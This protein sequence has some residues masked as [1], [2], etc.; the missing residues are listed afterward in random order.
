MLHR[1]ML[2]KEPNPR[3]SEDLCRKLSNYDKYGVG[4]LQNGKLVSLN[5]AF[6]LIFGYSMDSLRGTNFTDLIKRDFRGDYLEML[7]SLEKGNSA[8]TYRTPCMRADGYEIWTEESHS[9]I[10]WEGSSAVLMTVRE[11]DPSGL[12]ETRQQENVPDQKHNKRGFGLGRI[13]GKS[14]AMETVYELVLKATGSDSNVFIS[15]ESGT[16]KELVAR[17]IHEMSDRSKG[18]FVPINSG[19]IPDTLFESEFFGY[20]KGAF[21]G[22]YTD[23]HGFFDLAQGGTLFLDE[24]GEL[25][26]NAQVKLLRAIETGEYTPVGQNREKS[27]E[28]RI[29]AATNRKLIEE[30]EN[31]RIREDFFYRIYVIPIMLPPLRD[32]K[33]D[34]PLLIEHFLREHSRGGKK[35]KIPLKIMDVF[36][37]YEWPGNVRELQNALQRYTTLGHLD[38]LGTKKAIK[39]HAGDIQYENT[40]ETMDLR[41]EME[42]YEKRLI[43]KAL[44]KTRWHKTRAA[45]MLGL[46]RRT[47][48]RKLQHFGLM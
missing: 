46:P 13:I 27:I 18:C 28:T 25:T 22:A 4:V 12:N 19:A 11:V 35:V 24:V 1:E 42:K 15:G 16:G 14:P 39:K 9:Q 38:F 41:L 7:S 31:G 10:E 33:D 8:V 36:C 47:F 44:D 21:T 40:V 5:D 30:V 2:K 17:T 23:K 48:T 29:I 43:I 26:L 32:R 6:A 34:I 45:S 3:S 37:D 20:R